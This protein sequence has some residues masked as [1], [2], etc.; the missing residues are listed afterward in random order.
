MKTMDFG[1][2][3]PI[4]AARFTRPSYAIWKKVPPGLCNGYAPTDAA[5]RARHGNCMIR[6]EVFPSCPQLG[7][8][9]RRPGTPPGRCYRPV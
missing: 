4:G 6:F 3:N 7:M 5:G 2:S 9:P 1:P 8:V